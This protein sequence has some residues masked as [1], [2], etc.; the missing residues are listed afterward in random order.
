M[1]I[2]TCSL[3]ADDIKMAMHIDGDRGLAAAFD[4]V[5]VFHE[6]LFLAQLH[7]YV[8]P[9][10]TMIMSISTEQAKTSTFLAALGAEPRRAQA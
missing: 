3:G 5:V 7:V 6:K 2:F 10:R 1:L 8:G 9:G 4:F